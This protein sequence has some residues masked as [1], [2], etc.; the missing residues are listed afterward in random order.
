MTGKLEVCRPPT[1][2]SNRLTRPQ[3]FKFACY[4]SI[5]VAMT[6]AFAASPENLSAIIANVR[7]T[8]QPQLASSRLSQRAYVVYPKEGPRPPSAEELR[9]AR[10]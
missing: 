6:L 4:L 3:A 7:P 5:P 10:R 2:S 9:Q 8:T 1:A